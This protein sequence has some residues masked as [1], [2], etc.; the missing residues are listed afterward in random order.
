LNWLGVALALYVFMADSLHV[1]HQ[2]LDATRAVLPQA[3]NWPMFVV[4]FML[5]AA[6]VAHMAWRM[7]PRPRPVGYATLPGSGL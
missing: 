2:G 4:A 1:V 7:R 6:P 5:M 3:F